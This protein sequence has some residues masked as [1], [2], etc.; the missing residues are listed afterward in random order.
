MGLYSSMFLGMAPF[1]SL[2]AGYVAQH[3]SAPIAVLF[4]GGVSLTSAAI[5]ASR[6]PRIRID[7]Y[8]KT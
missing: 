1:G 6:L 7:D 5:F 4:C 8:L 2:I 3:Y